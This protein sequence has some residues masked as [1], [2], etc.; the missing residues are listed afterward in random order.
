MGS[1]RSPFGRSVFDVEPFRRG[2]IG[3]GKAPAVDIVDKEK[4]YEITAELPGMDESNIDVKFSDGTLTIKGEKREEKEEKK[5]DYY[6]SER[7]YGSFQRSFSV[8]DGVDADKIE[9]SFKNGVL[10]VTLPKTPKRR[11]AKRRSPSRRPEAGRALALVP[12]GRYELVEPSSDL[13]AALTVSAGEGGN[14]ALS[15]ATTICRRRCRR[16]CRRT[17]RIS[18]AKP[19]IT[20]SRPMPAIRA[21][22]R[23][24]TASPGRRSSARM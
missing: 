2:E 18:T 11:R 19:S 12:P 1:W 5:K 15:N 10:T 21:R 9:A 3:W 8:P 7:R 4:A 23:R 20:P 13:G 14:H 22:K 17:P 24:R 6:L 16:T